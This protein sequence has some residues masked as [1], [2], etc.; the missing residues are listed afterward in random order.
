[1]TKYAYLS[2]TGN[3][4]TSSD[5]DCDNEPCSRCGG[6]DTYLGKYETMEELARVMFE[7]DLREDY[8]LEVTGYEVQ[9][10]KKEEREE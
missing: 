5:P 7:N 3:F 9:F 8:I 2:C 1:M 4:Y 10:V 6:Y